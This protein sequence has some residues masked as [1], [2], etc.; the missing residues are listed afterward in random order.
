M[1]ASV[2]GFECPECGVWVS[3]DD[4][5]TCQPYKE[6]I[7]EMKKYATQGRSIISESFPHL[8]D[9]ESEF[10]IM[11]EDGIPIP[12]K[13]L[14]QLEQAKG[15]TRIAEA[16]ERIADVLEKNSKT[17]EEFLDQAKADFLKEWSDIL[18]EVK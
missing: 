1:I 14:G 18:E 3:K 2:P 16:L 4:L 6:Y 7:E 5:H 12:L 10:F 8:I 15:L 9:P 11:G 17:S 13:D